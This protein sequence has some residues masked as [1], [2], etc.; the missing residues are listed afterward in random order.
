MKEN[1]KA[2]KLFVSAVSTAGVVGLGLYL[3]G[4]L[5]HSLL[6]WQFVGIDWSVLASSVVFPM[7]VIAFLGIADWQHINS[8]A[9]E[10]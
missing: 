10:E 7:G 9:D 4:M 3:F 8:L 6:I 5:T 1:F 2:F